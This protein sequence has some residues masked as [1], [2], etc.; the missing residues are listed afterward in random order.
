VLAAEFSKV[1]KRKV[2]TDDSKILFS[3]QLSATLASFAAVAAPTFI[4]S[5]IKNPTL[6][7]PGCR[8]GFL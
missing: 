3:K 6:P 5:F 1:A 7:R 4:L 8:T 2:R